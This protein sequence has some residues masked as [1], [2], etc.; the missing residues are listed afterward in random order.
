MPGKTQNRKK[1]CPQIPPPPRSI[2]SNVTS[3]AQLLPIFLFLGS[4]ESWLLRTGEE[5]TRPNV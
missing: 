5:K 4:K 3:Y 1:V 2:N